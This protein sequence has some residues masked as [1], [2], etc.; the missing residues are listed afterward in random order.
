MSLL[1]FFPFVLHRKRTLMLI[2]S[3][4]CSHK[5]TSTEMAGMYN[6]SRNIVKGFLQNAK[7][8]VYDI[9]FKKH[10]LHFVIYLCL[11]DPE[12]SLF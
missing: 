7:V 4:R 12:T 1:E 10:V 5:F 9:K 11:R 8:S 6:I 2:I 3:F